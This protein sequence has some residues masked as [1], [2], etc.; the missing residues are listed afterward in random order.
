MATR[1]LKPGQCKTY[2]SESHPGRWWTVV[3][4]GCSLQCD[5]PGFFYHGSCWHTRMRERELTRTGR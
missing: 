2:P 3:Y 1:E 4:D 5:C